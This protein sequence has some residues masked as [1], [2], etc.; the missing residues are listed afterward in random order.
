MH[1]AEAEMM[2]YSK[3]EPLAGLTEMAQYGLMASRYAQAL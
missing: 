1:L 2:T 3:S